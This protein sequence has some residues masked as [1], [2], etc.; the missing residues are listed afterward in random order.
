MPS[1]ARYS[2]AFKEP[3]VETCLGEVTIG[4]E[5][6]VRGDGSESAYD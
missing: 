1:P 3:N 4:D 5:S 2:V 6:T